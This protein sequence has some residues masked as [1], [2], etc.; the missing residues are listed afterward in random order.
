MRRVRR[1]IVLLTVGGSAGAALVGAL[2]GPWLLKLVFGD[3]VVL[4]SSLTLLLAVAS[5]VAM[6][7]LVATLLVIAHG[8]AL[9]LARWW[10]VALVP[11]AA[12]FVLAQ[13]PVLERTCWAFLVVEVVAFGLLLREG[14]RPA[15]RTTAAA[16]S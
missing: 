12:W 7:N 10:A 14:S 3:D 15:A 9:A 6:A 16:A 2:A 1:G 5:T 13:V 4:S 11:G 8:R